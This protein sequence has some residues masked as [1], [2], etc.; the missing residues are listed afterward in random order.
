MKILGKSSYIYNELKESRNPSNKSSVLKI[1]S[2]H[3]LKGQKYR[4]RKARILSNGDFIF[5][6]SGI[7]DDRELNIQQNP[8]S[9]TSLP[10]NSLSLPDIPIQNLVVLDKSAVSE[11]DDYDDIGS[12]NESDA[13]EFSFEYPCLNGRIL[14]VK[15]Y[16]KPVIEETA[17]SNGKVYINDMCHDEN[18]DEDI[19]YDNGDDM[20][21]IDYNYHDLSENNILQSGINNNENNNY[22]HNDDIKDIN[23]EL[24]TLEISITKYSNLFEEISSSNAEDD[25]RG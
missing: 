6:Q 20:E 17:M 12:G 15:Y 10:K 7:I 22:K 5:L 23:Q 11:D 13:S 24:T 19:N 21:T 16:S 1:R 2:T 8:K 3:A 9:V 4:N 25:K 14:S 18:F